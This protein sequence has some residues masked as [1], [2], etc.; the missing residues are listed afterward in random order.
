M[1]VADA[2]VLI[3]LARMRRLGLLRHLYG[4]VT[5]GPIVKREVVDQGR[6]IAASGVEQVETALIDGWIAVSPLG[7]AEQKMALQIS[8]NSRLDEGEAES[9]ALAHATGDWLI[10][11]D[12]EARALAE[13]LHL[14]YLGTAAV[15]LKGFLEGHLGIGELEEAVEELARTI[16]LSPA[17]V[18]EVLKRAREASK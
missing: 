7:P 9:I 10:V 12:K 14:N 13:A 18:A 15:L 6:A 3:A 8:T 2:S 16:W 1:A 17:V 5:I 11:D 4:N